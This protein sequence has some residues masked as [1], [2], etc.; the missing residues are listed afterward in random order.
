MERSCTAGSLV[1]QMRMMQHGKATV[2]GDTAS[3][4]EIFMAQAEPI[5]FLPKEIRSK[6]NAECLEVRLAHRYML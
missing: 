2:L 5:S 3:D 1:L 4:H 6:C